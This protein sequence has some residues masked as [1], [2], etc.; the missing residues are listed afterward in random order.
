MIWPPESYFADN[1]DLEKLPRVF[2]D[3]AANRSGVAG[4]IDLIDRSLD[5]EVGFRWLR[6]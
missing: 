1:P 5:W 3:T 2:V 6:C 4:L